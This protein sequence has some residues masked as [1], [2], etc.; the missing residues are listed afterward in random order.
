MKLLS[1][2]ATFEY[3]PYENMP[4]QIDLSCYCSVEEFKH[5][6]EL[7]TLEPWSD[8]YITTE[9][10]HI[11]KKTDKKPR[12]GGM[13]TLQDGKQVYIK[14]VI[15][16][17]PVVIVFWSD[18]VKTRCTCSEED[19][20]NPEF[21]LTLCTLKRFMSTEYINSMYKD[22]LVEDTSTYSSITLKDVRT[23]HKLN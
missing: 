12:F 19:T 10:Q 16:N 6:Q 15:Y 4:C 17:K 13:I 22:W 7:K 3:G 1:Y 18:G 11:E 8:L 21:G 23:K 2:N 20:F 9:K 14:R 5:F